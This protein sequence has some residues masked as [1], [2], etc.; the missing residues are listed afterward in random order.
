MKKLIVAVLAASVWRRRERRTTQSGAA[1]ADAEEAVE[2]REL[3]DAMLALAEAQILAQVADE[4]SIDSRTIGV[5]GLNGVLLA[6]TLAARTLLGPYWWTAL[7]VT[8]I[9]TAPCLWS[10]FKKTSAFG[11]LARGFYEKFA[12]L[13]PLGA[14]AQLLVDLDFAF[15]FNAKR[16]KWKTRRLRVSVVGLVVGLAASGLLIALDR[17]TTIGMC[18]RDQIAVLHLYRC[19]PRRISH[20]SARA[21]LSGAAPAPTEPAQGRWQSRARSGSGVTRVERLTHALTGS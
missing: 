7:V 14:R 13:G 9:A 10:V 2:Q 19:R 12:P 11:P 5:L 6:G 4:A 8:G 15:D 21:G 20:S 18:S 17:P 3:L 16:V 1:A